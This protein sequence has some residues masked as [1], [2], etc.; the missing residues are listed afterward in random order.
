MGPHNKIIQ[1]GDSG[2]EKDVYVRYNN[3][4]KKIGQMPGYGKYKQSS[5]ASTHS[6]A[7]NFHYI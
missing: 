7:T 6:Q 3:G 2:N 4:R 1:D 5:F